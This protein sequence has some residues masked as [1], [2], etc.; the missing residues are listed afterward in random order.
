[1]N[2]EDVNAEG[3]GDCQTDI[4]CRESYLFFIKK[5]SL[6]LLELGRLKVVKFNRFQ[7]LAVLP[8]DYSYGCAWVFILVAALYEAWKHCCLH[9]HLSNHSS[10]FSHT[11][12]QA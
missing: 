4:G 7:N 2:A 3:C 6:M 5:S 8:V 1:M 12:C 9:T 10:C 11:V